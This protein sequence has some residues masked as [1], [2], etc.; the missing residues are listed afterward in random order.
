MRHPSAGVAFPQPQD[1][2]ET[3][4]ADLARDWLR[5]VTRAGFVPGVRARARAALHD[6]LEELV[7]A[8]RAEPFDP[9]VGHRIGIEL[10]DLRMAAP[11]VIGMT[12]RLLAER[13]PTLIDPLGGEIGNAQAA[14]TELPK[15][16]TRA[17]ER[18]AS[19]KPGTE[20]A[21]AEGKAAEGKAAE[22]IGAERIGAERIGAERIGAERIGAERIGA[23]VGGSETGG[24]AGG[25][26]VVRGRVLALLEHV[27][28]GFVTAQR[29]VAV[30]AAEQM[31]R[32]EKIHW[33]QVQ[34]DLQQRLQHAL[35]HEP[36]T[37][38]PNEQHLRKHLADQ[39]T[40]A[41]ASRMGV[42]LLAIDRY[43][44]LADT[45]GHDNGGKLL[46]AVA[47]RL[48]KLAE[49]NGYFLAHLGDDQFAV[50]VAGTGGSEEVVRVADQAHAVLHPPLPLDGHTLR[51]TVTAGIVED[52][53]AGTHP[54]HWLRDARL[55]LGWARHDHHD[56]AVFEAVRAEEERHRHRLA[57]A[58]PAALE[59]GEFLAHYQ[60]LY[61]LEDRTIVGV[62]ALARWRR[63]GSPAPLS[64]QHF[65]TLAENTGLIRP[66]GRV[67]L[68]QA[69]RQG[70]A[71]RHAGHDLMISVNL[72]PLQLGESS[73][74][75][76]VADVLHRT[77]LPAERL[78]LEITESSPLDE[79]YDT[80]RQL[81]DLGVRLALDDFGTGWSSLATLSWLPVSNAKLAAEFIADASSAPAVEVLRHTIA[82]CHSLGVSV[83]AEGIETEA[84]DRLLRGLGCDQGQG[85]NFARP[86]AAEEITRLLAA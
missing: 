78:Q 9:A 10:V 67:L 38:L 6:L 43:A 8:V 15:A 26:E 16:E 12:V 68:E 31:N 69:C 24:A 86:A 4:L 27:A 84:Q 77:G 18:I 74:I 51:V 55:A 59:D 47:C 46:T 36:R 73:L 65:I 34:S 20:R 48:H 61:R 11:P 54:D 2:D 56:R 53:A 83:T 49:Q 37:G 80:L 44:E 19:E 3:G 1:T 25:V 5:E 66:L 79:G 22:G 23:A 30:R 63:P 39:I 64:P 7:A 41:A 32:S 62:E 45:L 33:R 85:F 60:P 75:D 14:G 70:A 57:A 81:T 82:L 58:L 72:S 35:L 42:C 21:A 71:W 50:A 40:R 76:D 13:L 17:A 28:T 52:R 29:D